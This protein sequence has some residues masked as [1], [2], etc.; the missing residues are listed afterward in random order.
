MNTLQNN[1]TNS[2]YTKFYP[3][4]Q[5]FT[6]ST[7]STLII[8]KLEFWFSYDRYREG[9]YKF[10][11]P[12]AHPLYR[13][14]DSW[15]EELGVS[16]KL[17]AKAFDVIGIRYNSKS[18]YLKAQDKFQGKLY[19]SYHDRKT[20]RVY[21]VRNHQFVSQLLERL[22]KKKAVSPSPKQTCQNSEKPLEQNLHERA[23]CEETPKEIPRVSAPSALSQG[24]SWNGDLGRSYVRV[25]SYI[26]KETSSLQ[27]HKILAD[28]PSEATETL[29]TEEMIK[30]WNEEIGE[31][32][33]TAS[34]G[35]ST[36]L[37]EAFNTLFEGSLEAWTSYCQMISSSKFLMG[38]AQNRFFKKAW[39]T[40]AIRKD[41]I[42]R[43][44]SGEFQLGDRKTTKDKKVEAID[45]EIRQAEIKKSQIESKIY[46][47]KA[48]ERERRKKIV[49][50]KIEN[51]TEK[52][53]KAFEEDFVMFLEK[54]N[55]AMTK[56]FKTSGWKG[57]FVMTYFEGFVEDKLYAQLF[58]VSKEKTTQEL[59]KV[60][61]LL[62]HLNA[63]GEEI[64][65]LHKIRKKI[66]DSK[67]SWQYQHNLSCGF[68]HGVLV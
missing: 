64:N 40:W 51:L 21:F 31:L 22:L 25:S 61:G 11:E 39:M 65:A 52:E 29:V 26:H 45:Q 27:Q 7:I 17:F 44:L 33:V 14:G 67:T 13:K 12:C 36:H 68:K 57:L 18:A 48:T 24:R 3:S 43:I 32:G 30:I 9:F 1:L 46:N 37:Y 2:F 8:G 58:D 56:E 42:S 28:Q 38:E 53:K 47:I 54:K 34:R 41:N 60:S 23:F 55:D 4:L 66:E 16:R 49:K 63:A 6:G 19:A 20:N 50:E 62:E 59:L 35:L 10:V 15:S 5:A